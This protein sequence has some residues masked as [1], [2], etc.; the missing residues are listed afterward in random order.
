MFFHDLI[1]MWFSACLASTPDLLVQVTMMTMFPELLP[2]CSA[3][4]LLWKL[5]CMYRT[6]SSTFYQPCHK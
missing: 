6:F 3:F 1:I 5:P 2:R 4:H